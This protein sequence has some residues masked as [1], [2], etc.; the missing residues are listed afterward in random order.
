MPPPSRAGDTGESRIAVNQKAAADL[1]SIS[2]RTL[3][4]WE[5]KGIV[6]GARMGGGKAGKKLYLVDEL[7]AA[8]AAQTAR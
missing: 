5:R 1:L 3:Y 8:L 4:E 6:R 7:R 2:T